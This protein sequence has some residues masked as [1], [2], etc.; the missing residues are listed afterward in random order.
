M[1]NDGKIKI[2]GGD[3]LILELGGIGD[4]IMS[5]PA[6]EAILSARG[7][8][9]TTILTV[10]RTRPIIENLRRRGLH[11]FE[12]LATGALQRGGQGGGLSGWFW[13]LRGLRS[14]RFDAVIDLSAIET[15]GAAVKRYFF[16]KALGARETLGRDTGGKGWAFGRRAA[17]SL[18]SSEHETQRKMKVA[19]LFGAKTVRSAPAIA[20]S[21]EE[22]ERAGRL[23][24][25][26]CGEA[27]LVAGV[28][29]GAYRQSRM[30]PE[31]RFAEVIKWLLRDMM[32]CVVLTGGDRE[33]GV[34]ESLAGSFAGEKITTVVDI[35]LVELAAVIG[36]MDI[37]ITNDT[38]PMHI[39]AAMDVPVVALFGQTN[40]HRYHPY[41]DDSRYI[42]LKKG[43]EACPHLSFRHP[44]QECRRLICKGKECMTSIHAVEVKEAVGKLLAGRKPAGRLEIKRR[45]G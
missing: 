15:P 14:R 19:G 8:R 31:E 28:S 25:G 27:G 41:M 29:P 16:L 43:C 30:W 34:I 24:S 13:L 39:A 6:I 38:G 33:R 11:N 44:M 26:P 3:I 22:R 23:L 37:F 21:E 2:P 17:E 45:A 1:R 9:P 5:L 12:V 20:T 36:K 40:L 32:A 42:A 10:H 18:T 35:P 7:N 4:A